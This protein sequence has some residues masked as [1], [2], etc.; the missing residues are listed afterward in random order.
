M[1]LRRVA[2]ALVLFS[3]SASIGVAALAQRPAAPPAEAGKTGEPMKNPLPAD[4]S[5][6]QT[7]TVHGKTLHYTATV[8]TIAVD[9]PDGKAT[10]E[11][12]YTAYTVDHP[13]GE[14]DRPVLFALNGGPGAS[15]VYLNLGAVGPKHIAFANEGDS[16][17]D[18]A[19][20]TDNPGTWLD[21]ADLVFIDPIGTGFSRS[22]VDEAETKKLFYGPTVDVHYLSLV[23]YKWLVKYDRLLDKKYMMGESYGGYRCPRITYELQS[24]LGVAMNGLV[25]VSPYLNPDFGD[26]N[27]SPIPWMVTLP[28][29]TAA[30][31]ESQHKLTPDAMQKV[32][33]YTRGDYA[34]ALLKGRSDPAA[35]QAMIAKVTEMTGLDPMFVKYSGGRLSTGAYLREVHRSEGLIGSVYDSNVTA[36]D[37]FPYSPYQQSNDPILD[38]IIAPTTTAMADFI[39]RTVGWKTEARYNALSNDVNRMWDRSGRDLERG[40]V[41]ALRQAVAADPKFR[42][43]I[44]HGWND[45]SCAFMG[46][47]LSV[48]QMPLMGDP[49]RVSVHE[50]PGGHMFY[51]RTENSDGLH[52]LAAAMVAAH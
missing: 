30:H 16:P 18:P 28:S 51:T 34:E 2:C 9:G 26:G 47:V 20:L 52:Q 43:L 42:V 4:K 3:F 15:S 5:V 36:P 31:L 25:L 48:D 22:L 39:T 1:T 23:I 46:S 33:D 49:G 6:E 40:S 44:V 41:P 37:P 14:A 12:V 11:V 27:L 8:G 17:S 13:K 24:E 50:F 21:I 7:V 19:T 29:I 10:G 38:A 32:I 45:L 35:T